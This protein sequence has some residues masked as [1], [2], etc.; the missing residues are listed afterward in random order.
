M[1]D[2]ENGE[3]WS[4]ISRKRA[5]DLIHAWCKGVEKK[6]GDIAQPILYMSPSFA[7]DVLGN[8]S[9]LKVYPL[10]LAHYTTKPAPRIPKPWSFWTFWQ[11]TETGRV[12][13]ASGNVDIDRFNGDRSRLDALR[14]KAPQPPRST[15][16]KPSDITKRVHISLSEIE[17][18]PFSRLNTGDSPKRM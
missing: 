11:Y 7:T 14:V 10:W 5:V 16:K 3:L 9:R 13:G 8:D 6:L 2:V 1:L 15:G 4:G 12:S 18:S 17:E